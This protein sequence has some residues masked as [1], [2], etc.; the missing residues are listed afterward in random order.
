MSPRGKEKEKSVT[1]PW[2]QKKVT[3]RQRKKTCSGKKKSTLREGRKKSMA[4]ILEERE[5]DPNRGEG[6]GFHK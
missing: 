3:P 2:G 5:S 6:K 1:L 4:L